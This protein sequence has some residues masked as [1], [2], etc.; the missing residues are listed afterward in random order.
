MFKSQCF[1][2]LSSAANECLWEP[3]Q[4]KITQ[5]NITAFIKYLNLK[6]QLQL[7]SFEDLYLW[8]VNKHPACSEQ[9]T[10]SLFW[11]S[12]I[13]YFAINVEHKVDTVAQNINDFKKVTWFPHTKLNFT[14]NLLQKTNSDLAIIFKAENLIERKLSWEELNT[15]VSKMQQFLFDIGVKANDRIAFYLPN[16]PE[17]VVLALAAASVGAVCSFCS[18]DFGVQ[19]VLDRFGQIQP[20]LFIYSDASIYNGKIIQDFKKITNI[21]EQLP[22]VT[23]VLEVNYFENTET[24]LNKVLYANDISVFKY[25]TIL[26]QYQYKPIVFTKFPFNHPLYI[27]YSSGTTGV[28]KCIVHGVGG[29]LIQHIKEHQLHCDLKAGDKVFY[30]T[31]CGWMMWQWLVSSLASKCTIVLYD[32]SPFYP[33]PEVLFE[34]IDREQVRFFGTSAKYIDAVRKSGF[35]PKE[36][37]QFAKMDI[38]GSTGSPLVAES[39]EFVYENIKK[40]VCL[41]SL[42]GGTDIISCFVLGN[43]IGKV[44]KGEIQ[45][46]GLGMKV[47]VFNEEGKSIKNAKGE[48]VC[49]LPF[50]SQPIFFWQDANN[51]KYYNSYFSKFANIWYHG[52][53]A[54]LKE[55]GGVVIY[56]RSDATLN[57]GG[58][59]IGTAEIYRQVE[60]FA[61]ISESLAVDQKWRNDTRIILF[62]KLKQNC[63]LDINLINAIKNKLKVNCS[64]RHVPA[65]I[66]PVPDIPR[67]RSGKIVETAVRNVINALEVKNKESMANPEVLAFYEKLPELQTE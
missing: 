37:Y 61:E 67:T 22:T 43:P 44:F 42:S 23:H 54:E 12:I 48:L 35:I 11:Q 4:E 32:G 26:N 34:Y 66:I 19:G 7:C 10:H 29:T 39:F 31:T 56:G 13:E 21:L 62:V 38:I 17:T 53:W 58:V 63:S 57:P 25:Q 52:D 9:Q 16:I 33:S 59:R 36:K 50:P 3:S 65:K 47:E 45:T 60:Q 55:N 20:K 14:Q 1:H 64:P 24:Y 41:S 5:A 2:V 18:P 40:D 27:M 51:E 6:Y 28:P 15:A 46:R 30:Y 8:S 49:T